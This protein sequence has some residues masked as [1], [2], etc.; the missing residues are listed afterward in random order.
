MRSNPNVVCTETSIEPQDALLF[1]HFPETISHPFIWK[2]TISIPRL[3]LKSC[4]DK[5][6]RQAEET[7]KEPSNRTRSQSLR[8][9]AQRRILQLLFRLGE[10]RKLSK[11]QRHSS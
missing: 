5:I 7:G 11:I 3:L 8:P 4:L 1:R 10:E 6:K 2:S 9:R